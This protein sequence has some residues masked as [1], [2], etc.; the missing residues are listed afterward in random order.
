[1]KNIKKLLHLTPLL[2]PSSGPRR[3]PSYLG[4]LKAGK[5]YEPTSTLRL[6]DVPIHLIVTT[7]DTPDMTTFLPITIILKV[8]GK[9]EYKATISGDPKVVCRRPQDAVQIGQS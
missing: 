8:D 7:S 9:E 2:P 5:N 1:M 3:A 6:D 4:A